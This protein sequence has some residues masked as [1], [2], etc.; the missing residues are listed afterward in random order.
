MCRETEIQ[1]RKTPRFKTLESTLAAPLSTQ[2]FFGNS[3]VTLDYKGR[4]RGEKKSTKAK[5]TRT[6]ARTSWFKIF[7]RCF[8]ARSPLFLP[9]FLATRV[10]LCSRT[11]GTSKRRAQAQQA[12]G[13]A[14][15]EQTRVPP[16]TKQRQQQH[17]YEESSG[18]SSFFVTTNRGRKH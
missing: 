13:A 16:K 10:Y 9:S 14:A 5:G 1:C 17:H 8:L 6:M 4:K 3:R 7:I 11:F 18:Q 15:V 2:I 12:A